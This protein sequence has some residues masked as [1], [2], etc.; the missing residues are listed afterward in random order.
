MP[1]STA[2]IS[3][4]TSSSSAVPAP[5]RSPAKII[6]SA[7]GSMTL[8]I[9]LQR[10]APKDDRR[11][12]QQRVG[13]AHAGVGVDRH[14]EEH[15]ERDHRDL[16]RLAD[17]QPEDQQRQQRDLRDRKRG[18][19][20]RRAHRLGHA[21][22]SRPRRPTA[23][24]PAPPTAKP[25]RPGAR[26]WRPRA[27]AA[28]PSAASPRPRRARR[29]ATAGRA[30][31][32]SPCGVEQLPEPRRSADQRRRTRSAR[33]SGRARKRGRGSTTGS[34]APSRRRPRAAPRCACDLISAQMRSTACTKA[35]SP[36]M[37]L[38]AR[39]LQLDRHDLA[40]RA[41]GRR[42]S[43]T[44]RSAMNTASWMLCVT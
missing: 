36:S 2:I 44:T 43:T 15:A 22:R 25:S 38:G 4:A 30:P 27:R 16:G 40:A 29:A 37:A 10:R 42:E 31:A 20:E 41:P 5:S 33:Y 17:A 8:R 9:T 12:H 34:R 11:P 19:D 13:L 1:D 7:D 26:G 39:A 14:R 18:G 32:P 3:A 35:G 23:T 6:G 21:R 28:R 24:P